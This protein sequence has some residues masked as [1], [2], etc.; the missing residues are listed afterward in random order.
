MTEKKH[1]AECAVI[2]ELI[3]S[4]LREMNEKDLRVVVSYVRHFPK[5]LHSA[6]RR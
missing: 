5:S 1:S 4:Y 2:I 6:E 3:N